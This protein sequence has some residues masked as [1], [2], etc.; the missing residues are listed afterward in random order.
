M[1][2]GVIFDMDGVI[3]A[4]QIIH[5]TV[6]SKILARYGVNIT[7]QEIS[8][9]YSGVRPSEFFDELLKKTGKSYDLNALMAEKWATVEKLAMVSVDPVEGAVE[10]I[11]RLHKE[12]YPLAVAS[13]SYSD[14]VNVVLKQLDVLKYFSFV[15]TGDLVSKGKPDPECFLLAATKIKIDPKNCLVIEDG[16]SGMKGAKTAGM[17]CIGLV[18]DKNKEYLTKNLVTSLFEVTS[19][20]LDRLIK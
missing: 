18:E 9:R 1:I 5:A 3:S 2:K 17:Y 10:L 11:K 4:T 8:A 7:P 6:E 20:Y 14:Y 15:V 19:E 13:S 12:G 16:I